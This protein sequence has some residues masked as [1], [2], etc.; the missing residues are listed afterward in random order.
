MM[1]AVWSRGVMY[2]VMRLPYLTVKR[3]EPRVSPPGGFGIDVVVSA[4]GLGQYVEAV[5]ARAWHCPRRIVHHRIGHPRR[6]R[7]SRPIG[8][9]LEQVEDSVDEAV[10]ALPGLGW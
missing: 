8:L 3:S 1:R 2:G 7:I 6:R 9:R 5:V 4:A 10:V